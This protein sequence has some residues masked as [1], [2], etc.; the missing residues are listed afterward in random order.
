M[1]T[2]D[3]FLGLCVAALI[4]TESIFLISARSQRTTAEDA[5]RDAQHQL[6]DLK[7]QNEQLKADNAAAQATD[8]VSLR[9]ENKN[10]SQKFS[11]LQDDYARLDSTNKWLARQLDSLS[12]TALQ[13]QQQL[14]AWAT[15]SREATATVQQD[16]QAQAQARKKAAQDRDVC[17]R[18]LKDIDA[19]KQKWALLNNKTDLDIPTERELLTYL[20]NGVMPVCP[21]RGT[22]SINAVGLPPTCTVAGHAIQ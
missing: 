14:Q 19:A 17:I 12:E 6:A 10:L 16:T 9:A 3:L 2:K 15:A 5:L 21:A 13:Q 1:K 4:V 11:R 7:T 22:Y 18:N 20:P 8:I